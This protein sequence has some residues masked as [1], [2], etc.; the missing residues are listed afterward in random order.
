MRGL[1]DYGYDL[2]CASTLGELRHERGRF[3]FWVRSIC[4]PL[5]D[6]EFGTSLN[7]HRRGDVGEAHTAP[8]P[9]AVTGVVQLT[10]QTED[11]GPC[12]V[13]RDFR[14]GNDRFRG[15]RFYFERFQSLIV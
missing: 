11:R 10:L 4:A 14:L 7:G 5:T 1:D 3:G 8:V 9:C 6:Y 15:T 13:R 12:W 2:L